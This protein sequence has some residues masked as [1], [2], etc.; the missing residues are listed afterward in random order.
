MRELTSPTPAG[1]FTSADKLALLT[2][3][4]SVVVAFLFPYPPT[5]YLLALV[6]GFT[7]VTLSVRHF[8]LAVCFFVFF[9]PLQRLV[10]TQS[11]FV[12]GLNLQTV[13]IIYFALLGAFF[14]SQ[15]EVHREEQRNPALI[16]LIGLFLIVLLSAVHTKLVAG[17][18][19]SEVFS[20]AKNWFS[21]TFF[22]YL[23][24]LY[25]RE[26]H[27][28]LVLLLFVFLTV[29]L[30]SLLSMRQVFTA[31]VLD[32]NLLRHRAVSLIVDQPNLYG[33]FLAMYLFFFLAFLAFYPMSRTKRLIFAG[34][35]ALVALNLLYTFSRGA[36]LACML[37]ALFIAAAKSRRLLI[38]M[39]AV[40]VILYI[41]MPDT[42]SERWDSGFEGKYAMSHFSEDD[43][44]SEAALRI[45]QWKSFLP[46]MMQSPIFGIG[47][48]RYNQSLYSLGYHFEPRA[49]HSTVIEIGV[50]Q[51]VI[52]LAF[53]FLLLYVLY[54]N[55]AR[56]YRESSDPLDRALALGMVG[57]TICL[58]LLD[59][60][61]T[62]FRYNFVTAFYWILAGIT[63]NIRPEKQAQEPVLKEAPVVTPRA[64]ALSSPWARAL[65]KSIPAR[66]QG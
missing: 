24:F 46:M 50:E 30:N 22:V 38:P 64:L 40:A 7:F 26:R 6:L 42:A 54:R 47:L 16:P 37:T 21:Y 29:L 51:G 49:A 45:V 61:G 48:D 34:C 65:R 56:I 33:G 28:K 63:L 1:A 53:Y 17:Y 59:L 19:V 25:V 23:T 11:F 36:W 55:A 4:G 44:E 35:T 3:I 57:A 32:R 9:L 20:I 5:K 14:A 2:C 66:I 10:S 18:S 62:R 58:F 43:P 52:G 8:Y 12:P 31:V 60:T 13:F 41:W 15:S 39:A 27:Q